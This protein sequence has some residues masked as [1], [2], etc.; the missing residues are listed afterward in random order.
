MSRSRRPQQCPAPAAPVKR[1]AA[2][3]E[4][5]RPGGELPLAVWACAQRTSQWQR[6]RRYLPESNRHPAKMLPAL[7]RHAI[8]AYSDPGD[9]IVDPMCGVGTTL[10][11]AIHLD[12]RA[13]GV[14]LESRWATLANAN[15]QHA[16][17][18]GASGTARVIHGDARELA[19]LLDG[20]GYR[21]VDLI[22]TSPPYACQVADLAAENV[23]HAT[24]PLR[25][26]DTT[27]YSRDRANLGHARGAGYLTAMSDVYRACA[28]A[29]KPGG[30]MVIVTKDMRSGGALRNL[31]G[32][33]IALCEELGLSYWQRVIALHATLRDQRLTMRPSFWQTL[34]TRRARA[35]GERT[36]VTAHED[37]LVLRKPPAADAALQTHAGETA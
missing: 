10:V 4:Q 37:V 30:Y 8:D 32:Q 16:Y 25:R 26:E 15:V 34:H 2:R 17:Q 21:P 35:H 6:H 7:A 20:E 12:R 5:N 22:L 24:G 11:E 33:T 9:L 3:C 18:H 14:E 23:K 29:L 31:S 36:L 13:V 1:P 19:A 27:N 28:A